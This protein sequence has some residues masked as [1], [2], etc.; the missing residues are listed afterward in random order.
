MPCCPQAGRRKSRRCGRLMLRILELGH[1]APHPPAFSRAYLPSN[2][3]TGQ[4]IS[5]ATR[6]FRQGFRSHPARRIP[7]GRI[8]ARALS[9]LGI[10]SL[11]LQQEAPAAWRG[12][13]G[14][15]SEPRPTL[16]DGGGGSDMASEKRGGQPKGNQNHQGQ[17]NSHTDLLD[18][19]SYLPLLEG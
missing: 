10:W 1:G 12:L 5:R 16:W 2:T 11:L 9:N 13:G 14:D 7:A 17:H 19:F 4:S 6:R 18:H 8:Q 15:A 3:T